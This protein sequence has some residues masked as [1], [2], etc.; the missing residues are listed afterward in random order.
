MNKKRMSEEEIKLHYITPAIIE[1]G[2]WDRKQLRMEVYFTDGKIIVA[3]KT[4]KRGKRNFVDYILEYKPN[5][6]LAVVEAKDNN[7][8]IGAGMQQAREYAEKLD[9]PFAFSSNG[10]GFI[11]Y[12]SETGKETELGLNEFPTPKELWEK[13]KKYKGITENIEE[14][15]TANYFYEPGFKQPRYYQRIAINRTVEA[16]AKGQKRALLVLATGTGKTYVAFQTIWRLKKAGL[17]KKVLYLADR[18]ILI[19]QPK[20]NDFKPLSKVITKI[21]N[22]EIDKS[23]EVYLALYQAVSGEDD[24]KNIYKQFKPDSFDL[25]IVDECHRGSAKSD[26]QW[27]EILDYFKPAVQIGMTATPKETKDTSNIDYFGKPL[28]TYSLKEGID[29]G[30][31]APYKVVKVALDKD[32]HGYRPKKGELDKRG[33]EIPDFVYTNREFDRTLVI[34]ERTEVIAKKVTE[35]L[36]NTDR[37]AKTIVFCVDIEHAERMR[38]ALAN[39]NADL[40]K[41]NKK[42]VMRITGDDNIGKKHIDKFI[43]PAEKYPVIVTTSKLMNTG[44]DAQTCKLIVLDSSI[45][46]MTEFKQIIGRGTRIREDYGKH[47]FTIMDFRNVTNKFADPDFDGEPVQIYTISEDQEAT[48]QKTKEQKTQEGERILVNPSINYSEEPENIRKYYV[49]KTEVRVVNEIVQYNG[50]DGKLITESLTDFTKKNIKEKYRSLSDFIQ[51]WNIVDQKKALIAE[52]ENQGLLLDALKE[53]IPKGKEYDAFDL[54]AHIAYG[55]KPLTRSQRARKV[56]KDAYFKKYGEKA[57]KV[58]DALLEKYEDEGIEN[59]ED[60]EVL[61]VEPLKK[62]GRPLEIMKLFGGI[63]GYKKLI[64]ELEERLYKN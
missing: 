10:D 19:D 7:H 9:I 16:I 49:K 25:I 24:I 11:F 35:F 41:K 20:N 44:V 6:P 30:F 43:D 1:K 17:A 23:Y 50:P 26:S 3:G 37:F 36:K 64:K 8:G 61:R 62:F 58:I 47:Y 48:E 21:K 2:G 63:V 38:R 56:Q 5:I 4:V 42:Y 34:D 55:Q 46:S 27:R 32:V 57:R 28:Y 29:D 40:I 51:N 15:I 52:L 22:R 59:L 18:N 60:A 33:N 13:Y 12:D 14:T 53:E 31:L 54:I 39:E 45:Q